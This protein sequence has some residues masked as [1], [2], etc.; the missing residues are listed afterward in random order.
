MGPRVGDA[1]GAAFLAQSDQDGDLGCLTVERDDG[2]IDCD[3]ISM[4]FSGWTDLEAAGW[5]YIGRRV[6]DVGAG[7]GRHS[8]ELQERGHEVV[9]LDVSEGAIEVCR[10]RGVRET[11]H[12]TLA[13]LAAREPEPFDTALLFGHNLGLLQS[14]EEAGSFLD[15]LARLCRPEGR[16]VGTNRDPYR[17]DDSLHLAYHRRNR[18][19]GHMAG[20]LRLRIRWREVATDWFDLL[21]CSP[22]ELV[23]LIRRHG[24]RPTD[25]AIDGSS[26]L[27]VLQPP[28]A[29]G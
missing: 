9:A 16:V 2:F 17:T 7:A 3:P 29:H 14:P 11:F 22:D 15:C 21:F 23:T 10:R 18:E 13:D 8:L 1:F 19:Q 5:N 24:W 25:R 26:Y 12:G 6:L 27:A 20:Q 28:V 4:Y